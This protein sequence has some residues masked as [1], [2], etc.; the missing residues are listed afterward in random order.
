MSIGPFHSVFPLI[1]N[2]LI[3]FF[4]SPLPAKYKIPIKSKEQVDISLEERRES[5]RLKCSECVRQIKANEPVLRWQTMNFCSQNCLFDHM[6]EMHDNGLKCAKCGASSRIDILGDVMCRIGKEMLFFCGGDCKAEFVRDLHLCEFCLERMANDADE[7]KRFCSERCVADYEK[8]YAVEKVPITGECTDCET[9]TTLPIQLLYEG[10]IYGF[11]SF[12][13]FFFLKFSCGIYAGNHRS[14]S[15]A[16]N[17]PQK[18]SILFLVRAFSISDQCE[19]CEKY[20]ERNSNELFNVRHNDLAFI[21][22]SQICASHFILKHLVMN[23]CAFCGQKRNNFDMIQVVDGHGKNRMLCSIKCLCYNN[24]KPSLVV[25][26][27]GDADTPNDI[28]SNA[29]PFHVDKMICCQPSMETRATQSTTVESRHARTQTDGWS[30]KGIIPIPVPIY[31]PQLCFVPAP[32]PSPMPFVLPIVVPI[33]LALSNL[34][35][36]FTGKKHKDGNIATTVGRISDVTSNIFATPLRLTSSAPEASEQAS[37][38]TSYY[39]S[40]NDDRT[41]V[42]LHFQTSTPIG[43]VAGEFLC[44]IEPVPAV[45]DSVCETRRLKPDAILDAEDLKTEDEANEEPNFSQQ[46]ANLDVAK[47]IKRS[48]SYVDSEDMASGCNDAKKPKE[49][50]SMTTISQNGE[51]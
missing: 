32:Y 37:V 50:L 8:L 20:F 4:V 15:S 18:N 51:I 10:K 12:R 30:A 33:I 35:G 34:L 49:S 36:Q 6:L 26:E 7:D 40:C 11:C 41:N 24:K 1:R 21:F 25:N 38:Q 9:Y 5:F 45:S 14:D 13:C 43:S 22:C 31:V 23:I 17:S 48:F 3:N 46:T 47:R 39:E 19:M 16:R 42:S 29:T 2:I 28:V 27:E 44:D